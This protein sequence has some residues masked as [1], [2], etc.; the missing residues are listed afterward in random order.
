MRRGENEQSRAALTRAVELNPSNA[1]AHYNLGTL[2]L[3][4]KDYQPAMA[5]LK[6]SVKINPRFAEA[7]YNLAASYAGLGLKESALSE[8]KTAIDFDRGLA[9]EARMDK[10][11]ATLQSDPE[12]L[13]I[14]RR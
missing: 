7:Y 13:A 9:S 11:F 8:L 3:K 10:D 2:L 4:M 6:E 12:F 5:A 14:T 1:R